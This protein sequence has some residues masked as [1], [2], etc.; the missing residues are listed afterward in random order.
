M[1]TEKRT[2]VYDPALRVEAYHFEGV[3]QAFPN[4][5]HRYYVIGL[6]EGGTRRLCCKGRSYTLRAGDIVVFN[7]GD[8]H[9]CAPCGDGTLYYRALNIPSEVMAGLTA[10]GGDAP[11]LPH[12]EATV[13]RDDEIARCLQP[14]HADIMEGSSEPGRE[15]SLLLLTALLHERCG[16]PAAPPAPECRAGIQAACAFMQRHYTEHLSLADIGRAAGL[17]RSTLLRAFTRAKGVTPYLYLQNVR[18]DA[19]KT[20]LEQGVAPVEAALQTGFSDQ[21]HFTHYFSRFIGLA[22][23]VYRDIFISQA[24]GSKHD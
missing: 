8:N 6:M 13:L 5:F 1:K 15:E 21:S 16:Q 23:G 9:A 12:F 17:T 2:V 22:P 20:L 19:A 10:A 24:G 18:I 14:L 4:H 3:V 7:P 11:T